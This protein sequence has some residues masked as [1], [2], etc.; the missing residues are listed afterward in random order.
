METNNENYK[1]ITEQL[2]GRI[3]KLDSELSE[4][5]QKKQISER[6]MNA[7]DSIDAVVVIYEMDTY[8]IIFINSYG[9]QL[10]G[11]SA[12]KKKCWQF[13]HGNESAPCAYC[14][15]ERL[16]DDKGVSTGV[17]VWESLNSKNNRWY[18]NHTQI[19]KIDAKDYK[20]E[21]SYDI[22]HRKKDEKR[23][24]K[25]LNQQ[26][27]LFDIARSLNSYNTFEKKITHTFQLIAKQLTV[28]K[29]YILEVDSISNV[30]EY[31][32]WQTHTTSTKKYNFKGSNLLQ[33]KFPIE[34][35]IRVG[36]IKNIE[37]E[38][39]GEDL[40]DIFMIKNAISNLFV[41]IIID[42][43]LIGILG[44]DDNFES[45]LWH[46]LEISYLKTIAELIANVYKRVFYE[47]EILENQRKLREANAS[48]DKFFSIIAHDLKNPVYNLIS[49]SDFLIKNVDTWKL[50]KIKEFV[51][52]IN[53]TSKQGFNLLENL[54]VWA[55][56][57]TG[58]LEKKP[59]T[60][61]VNALIIENI[62]LH[63]NLAMNKNI[64]IQ[65]V[66]EEDSNI[67]ADV[68]MISTVIRNLISN[69]IKYTNI[70]G[71][72]NIHTET[73]I[74]KN[75]SYQ[76]IIIQDSGVGISKK[77]IDRLFVI[78]KSFSTPGTN[79]EKGTGLGLILCK[80]FVKNNFG[81]IWVESE[82]GI[83]SKFIFTVP[84]SIMS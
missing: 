42:D 76:K 49:L 55:R 16:L 23:I 24:L 40:R 69:A 58:K 81:D 62:A 2:T 3:S 46:S 37:I 25:L 41:P 30:T 53:E 18:E 80:E 36:R 35:L 70:E 73:Q 68:N 4:L 29:V 22:T 13:L 75:R 31:I 26:N 1:N 8:E 60:F 52:Y 11:E 54:L 61:D 66:L 43:K 74:Y 77:D 33:Q 51:K 82:I 84:K 64:E 9:L 6:V 45:R 14:P 79:E 56:S 27:V 21:V 48:K 65:K 71:K 83:G 20:L 57:Q 78:D 5:K 44:I 50:E 63:K 34:E 17:Y 67:Y 32:E 59:M 7:I 15:N 28:N 10:F 39:L 19:I 72:I 47:N 12:L 38:Q